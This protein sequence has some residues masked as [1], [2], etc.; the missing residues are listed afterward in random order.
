MPVVLDPV[1]ARCSGRSSGKQPLEG[2][3]SQPY[4]FLDR[5]DWLNQVWQ[6]CKEWALAEAILSTVTFPSPKLPVPGPCTVS[7][8]WVPSISS[9]PGSSCKHYRKMSSFPGVSPVKNLP[10]MQETWEDPLKKEMKTHSSILAWKI[11][12]AE[13]PGSTVHGVTNNWTRLSHFIFHF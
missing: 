8:V 7:A 1:P 6:A 5:T 10:A 11:P 2:F 3:G 13:E 9:C 4:P 12:W